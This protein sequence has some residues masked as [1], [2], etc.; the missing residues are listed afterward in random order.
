MFLGSYK[1]VDYYVFAENE[2]TTDTHCIFSFITFKND[3]YLNPCIPNPIEKK[4]DSVIQT[5]NYNNR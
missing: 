2:M 5:L 3:D 1:A 4:S